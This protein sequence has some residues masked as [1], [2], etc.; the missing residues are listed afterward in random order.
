MKALK[1]CV[2]AGALML[3]Q[4]T[5]ALT[6][7]EAKQQGRVGET[8]TG[9]LAPVKQDKETL[10]FVESINTARSEKYQEIA[11]KNNIKATDVAKMAGEKLIARAGSGEF[12][13]GINGQW[14]QK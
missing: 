2:F 12:V 10:L 5:Y 8:L 7:E 14:T 13:R 1:L 6:L 3:S 4:F 11:V 9:Y